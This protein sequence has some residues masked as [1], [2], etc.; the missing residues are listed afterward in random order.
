MGHDEVE[1]P[2]A[3]ADG[4][5]DPRAEHA[6]QPRRGDLFRFPDALLKLPPAA[7]FAQG[8]DVEDGQGQQAGCGSDSP[9]Q[10]AGLEQAAQGV[11][12]IDDREI[13]PGGLDGVHC[14]PFDR[15]VAGTG[16]GY[17]PGTHPLQ[18]GREADR[19]G[20]GHR[21]NQPKQRREPQAED[22][23]PRQEANAPQTQNQ[24]TDQ[25]AVQ[26]EVQ[27]PIENVT[28]HGGRSWREARQAQRRRGS[29]AGERRRKRPSLSPGRAWRSGLRSLRR[30]P[31]L[32]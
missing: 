7:G 29:H 6:D 9:D 20:E 23:P 14:L 17:G 16:N 19:Q 12:S 31:A 15:S 2:S 13:V 30:R 8:Q 21:K 10:R 4:N 5:Q 27:D 11:G 32:W 25:A 28:L 26:T 3:H 1:Q 24:Q 22:N 18:H